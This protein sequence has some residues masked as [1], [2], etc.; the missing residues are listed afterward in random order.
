MVGDSHWPPLEYELDPYKL[1]MEQTRL[2]SGSVL[3]ESSSGVSA[4]PAH[5]SDPR[6]HRKRGRKKKTQINCQVAG[7][8]QDL[9]T[10]KEYFQRYQ[11][12]AEHC[13]ASEVQVGDVKLRFCQQC[14][15]FHDITAFQ[16]A[17]KSC[18]ASLAR[19]R[20]RRG[21]KKAK[22]QCGISTSKQALIR[23][24]SLQS[25]TPTTEDGS[26]ATG[27]DSDTTKQQPMSHSIGNDTGLQFDDMV[28]VEDATL[29]YPAKGSL[30]NW[31]DL[32]L[33]VGM[34]QR[35][36]TE[37]MLLSNSEDVQPFFENSKEL[38]L[39]FQKEGGLLIP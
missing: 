19:C 3:M 23:P 24:G 37:V 25:L 34:Y 35:V 29:I 14:A 7:C 33:G 8:T 38:E 22:T 6:T 20:A 9:S 26:A 12:C 2:D 10:F 27:R 36:G 39:C 4:S 31:D 30:S 32:A 11:I 1:S 13:N 18:R 16:K 5:S 21:A 17:R 28:S 15:S